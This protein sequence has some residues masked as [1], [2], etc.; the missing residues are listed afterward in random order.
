M[1]AEVGHVHVGSLVAGSAHIDNA[2]FPAQQPGPR[3]Q[4][5]IGV[6]IS[7]LAGKEVSA[8]ASVSAEHQVM[9]SIGMVFDQNV[10]KLFER[11]SQENATLFGLPFRQ[12]RNFL[13]GVLLTV[14]DYLS[15][16]CAAAGAEEWIKF[17]GEC[18]KVHRIY[19]LP[20]RRLVESERGTFAL[21]HRVRPSS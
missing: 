20:Y 2:Q 3:S 21:R 19:L 12:A 6:R 15:G 7:Q 1:L 13:D 10:G 8:G 18:V 11:L 14:G 9:L 4:E 16:S 5:G 17:V